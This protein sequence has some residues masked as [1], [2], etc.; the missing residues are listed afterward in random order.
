[1]GL[2]N[3]VEAIVSNLYEEFQKSYE[4]KCGCQH[5][6]E[7]ILALVLNRIPPK[8]T[9]SEKGQ[10]YIKTLYLNPQLQSDVMRELMRA[11]LV[12]EHKQN[13]AVIEGV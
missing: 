12:V 9:S 5:C 3:A 11:A 8:Y 7:D 10:L 1:M 13:H 2:V 4:I 6:K